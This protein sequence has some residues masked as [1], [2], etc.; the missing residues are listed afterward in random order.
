MIVPIAA[1][2]AFSLWAGNSALSLVSLSFMQMLV[3]ELPPH[4]ARLL[5][6]RS[7]PLTQQK[8]ATPCTVFVVGLVAGTESWSWPLALDLIVVRAWHWQG[9]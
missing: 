6:T 1:L 7:L 4:S 2:Y 3:R 9:K 5:Q 8:S